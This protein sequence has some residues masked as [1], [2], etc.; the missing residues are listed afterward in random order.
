VSLVRYERPAGGSRNPAEGIFV[1]V[2]PM[3]SIEELLEGLE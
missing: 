1:E 3:A 2:S